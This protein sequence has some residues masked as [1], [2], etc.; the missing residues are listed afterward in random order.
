MDAM[1]KTVLL[2]VDYLVEADKYFLNTVDRLVY[3]KQA[4]LKHH[5]SEMNAVC[6]KLTTLS[7]EAANSRASVVRELLAFSAKSCLDAVNCV[8]HGSAQFSDLCKESLHLWGHDWIAQFRSWTENGDE[9]CGLSTK[10]RA[11]TQMV[12]KNTR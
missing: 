11:C 5:S 6:N 10:S 2:G 3:D 9:S 4:P 8:A 12:T 1:V 7:T